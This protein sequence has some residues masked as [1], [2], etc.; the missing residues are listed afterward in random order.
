MEGDQALLAFDAPAGPRAE[1][2]KPSESPAKL[3]NRGVILT[4]PPSGRLSRAPGMSRRS[5]IWPRLRNAF[6][7]QH[8]MP[9]VGLVVLAGCLTFVIAPDEV[10]PVDNRIAASLDNALPTVVIDPGHGGRDD[11]ARANGLVE[12]ELTLDLGLRVKRQ[13]DSLGFKT[14][15]TRTND[16]YLTLPE[17]VA[18]ANEIENSY[19]VSLHFDQSTN[20]AASGVETFYASQKVVPESAWT[21][22]GYFEKPDAP[23]GADNGETF[24]GYVQTALVNRT[25]SANRGIRGRELYVVRHTRAPAVLVEGGF[26]SNPF[27][28]RLIATPEYRDRLAAAIVEGVVQY[29]KT[30][31]RTKPPTQLAKAVR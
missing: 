3:V 17:R 30:V 16:T 25:D 13:L 18:K 28:A 27:D 29:H 15:L 4:N 23:A 14:A 6:R 11:G 31:P 1:P 2:P 7:M 26:I 10:P 12:K 5:G 20:S 8:T 22:V 24:A 9:C 21:W 19:F